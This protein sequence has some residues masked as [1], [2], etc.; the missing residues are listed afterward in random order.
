M[1]L[2]SSDPA[3]SADFYAWLL[4]TPETE[5]GTWDTTA[6][7]RGRGIFSVTL[8]RP[9]GPSGGWIPF[10]LLRD[11]EAAGQRA[12]AEGGTVQ[13]LTEPDGE[14]RTYVVD[15]H[16]VWTGIAGSPPA[17]VQGVGQT[18]VDYSAVD[19]Q[20]AADYYQRV[21]GLQRLD[22]VNDPYDFRL[23]YDNRQIVAG[24]VQFGGYFLEAGES[25]WL[26]YFDVDD[27]DL[28]VARAVEAGSRIVVPANNST[29]NRYA[30]LRDPFGQTFGLSR[31]YAPGKRIPVPVEGA[32]RAGML[33]DF[34]DL[35]QQD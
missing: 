9:E 25:G 4:G 33:E 16:D 26:V 27:V 21:L 1:E 2:V 29:M 14:R 6:R 24:F 11:V 18:N 13:V 23:L 35:G 19:T 28:A 8:K 12:A 34:V 5:A 31:Y 3:A 15:G 10:F 30:V 22:V 20:T 7:L 17:D 32:E